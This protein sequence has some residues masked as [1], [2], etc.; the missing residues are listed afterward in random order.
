MKNIISNQEKEEIQNV[1]NFENFNL[2]P[3]KIP[4]WG[5]DRVIHSSAL[6]DA[7]PSYPEGLRFR[8]QSADSVS[9]IIL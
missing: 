9:I 1:I 3:R 4:A 6:P 5:L 8:S 2:G 7:V